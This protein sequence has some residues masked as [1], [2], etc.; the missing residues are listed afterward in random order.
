MDCATPLL[1]SFN[2]HVYVHMC[3]DVVRQAQCAVKRGGRIGEGEQ[4]VRQAL[5]RK[6]TEPGF[7]WNDRS[8][9]GHTTARA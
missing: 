2:T 6:E 3:M 5:G 4:L 9:C 1:F 7:I 8:K